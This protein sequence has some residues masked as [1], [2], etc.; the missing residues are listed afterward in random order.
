MY[1]KSLI[2]SNFRNYERLSVEFSEGTNILYGKNAQGKTNILEAVCLAATTKSQRGARDREMIRMGCD[3]GHIRMILV[4]NDNEYRIDIHL[5]KT[6][7][8]G[9]AVG[10]VP[11]R[12][13][14][15]LYGIAGI[16]Q[17]SPEDLNIIKNGPS[18]RRRF[19]DQILCGIDRIYMSDLVMYNRCLKERGALL[20]ELPFRSDRIG[21]LDIWDFKIAEI[22]KRIT[23]GRKQF[24]ADFSRKAREIHLSLTGGREHLDVI[25]EPDTD[26]EHFEERQKK[27]RETDLK[28]KST[29]CGPHRD[30]LGIRANDMDLRIYGSQGQQR[31]EA[32]SL[33]MAEI[34]TIEEYRHDMPVLLLDDVLSELDTERQT[35]LLSVIS[36]TQ[37][38]I[39]CTGLDEF[40]QNQFRTDR[41][42]HVVNGSIET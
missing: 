18:A 16:V 7:G 37:T 38:L 19:L 39:T 32:L 42:F 8:K 17:F 34:K 6:G 33:K 25:Y 29:N 20:K 11:V 31:T 12:K 9:I 1:V 27:M 5:K 28:L 21:E 10:G 24:T 3:E 23:A 36:R 26:E 14:S 22:G 15:D 13:A 30:D 40:V 35:A 4:K 2:L 41:I